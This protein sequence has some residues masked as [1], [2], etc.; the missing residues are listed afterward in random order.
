M[1]PNTLALRHRVRSLSLL[2]YS[3]LLFLLILFSFGDGRQKRSGCELCCELTTIPQMVCARAFGVF[4]DRWKQV[5][6]PILSQGIIQL[7]KVE[8]ME[9][10][11]KYK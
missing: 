6:P 7:I 9:G 11:Q 8:Q 1:L 2:A 4:G 10:A 5:Y 3:L